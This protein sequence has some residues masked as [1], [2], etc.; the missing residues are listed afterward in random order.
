MTD[1]QMNYFLT[2]IS[3]CWKH[4]DNMI[5]FINGLVLGLDLD[6]GMVVYLLNL[7]TH[8]KRDK[9]VATVVRLFS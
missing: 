1:N 7:Y 6:E 9:F 2:H 5:G 8:N 3:L 4:K